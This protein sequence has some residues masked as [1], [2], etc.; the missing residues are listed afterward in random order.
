[1]RRIQG[2]GIS[3][4]M[5]EQH[6]PSKPVMLAAQKE[7]ASMSAPKNE[8]ELIAR[9]Y[10]KQADGSWIKEPPEGFGEMHPTNQSS[11]PTKSEKQLQEQVANY[12]RQH[13]T[14]FC[15]SGMHR[16]TSTPV[17]TPDFLLAWHG[18]PVAIE[19]KAEGGKQTYEQYAVELAMRLNGWE[20]HLIRSLPELIK[21]LPL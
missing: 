20:Y 11:R 21:V 19:C 2:L 7:G 6:A 17:G 13:D 4:P 18:R 16:R 3:Y 5:P 8:A 10:V 15:R 9:G 14:W 12:L 1:M